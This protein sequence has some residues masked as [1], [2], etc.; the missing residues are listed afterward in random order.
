VFNAEVGRNSEFCVC[1]SS[2]RVLIFSELFAQTIFKH[3]P[4]AEGLG[5][6]AGGEEG[7]DAGTTGGG[8]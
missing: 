6:H 7:V 3:S 1:D 5:G 8:F 2:C 4:Q